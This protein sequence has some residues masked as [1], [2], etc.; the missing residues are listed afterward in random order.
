MGR[1]EAPCGR[2]ELHYPGGTE[3]DVR[4]PAVTC[5]RDGESRWAAVVE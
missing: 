4:P 5:V 2:G 3:L 1:Q